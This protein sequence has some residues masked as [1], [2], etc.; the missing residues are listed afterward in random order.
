[1]SQD[2][3]TARAA[4][5][6]VQAGEVEALQSLLATH[7]WLASTRVADRTLLHVVTDWPGHFP[8]GPETV[9]ALIAAG[10][11]VEAK[12]VGPHEERPLHW[13]ASSDDV[14]VLDS[15]L[16][17]GADIDAPG[18]VVGG[19]PPLADA[20]AFGQWNAA[21]R[22]VERGAH[23]DVFACAALGLTDLLTA[24][25][26][27]G[28]SDDDLNAAFWG[29]CHGGQLEAA[30]FLHAQG[31]ALD[32]SAPWESATPLDAADRAGAGDGVEWLLTLGTTRHPRSGATS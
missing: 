30:R 23:A 11:D 27:N 16:D 12:F 29:A 22:L 3:A 31:A 17:A 32:Q 21:L 13:A 5:A 7:P 1:M 20:V 28:L 6:A 2:D 25:V 15:L 9:A 14:A 26:A 4:V 19:G 24:Y 18:A 8:R 10:A